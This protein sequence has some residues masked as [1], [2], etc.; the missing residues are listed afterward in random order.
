MFRWRDPDQV[1]DVVTRQLNRDK[2]I[3][4]AGLAPSRRRVL[5]GVAAID[6]TRAKCNTKIAADR[7]TEVDDEPQES[8][9][10]LSDRRIWQA[11]CVYRDADRPRC[12]QSPAGK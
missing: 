9:I 7:S 2:E 1:E 10:V 3:G 8:V 12:G 6:L 4:W 11:K 5:P